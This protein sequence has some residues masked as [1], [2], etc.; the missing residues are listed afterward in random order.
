V[1]NVK[2]EAQRLRTLLEEPQSKCKETDSTIL[3]VMKQ[4]PPF[5]RDDV[6]SD[7]EGA[8]DALAFPANG[9][10]VFART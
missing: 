6:D 10:V 3:E 8:F 4:H 9:F 5:Y 2:A 1:E 7:S